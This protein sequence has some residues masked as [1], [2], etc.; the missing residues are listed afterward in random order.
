MWL[1]PVMHSACGL[2]LS[3]GGQAETWLGFP[4]PLG[5]PI[6]SLKIRVSVLIAF[7]K[8]A[9]CLF[10]GILS[11]GGV[12]A[13][14]VT[15]LAAVIKHLLRFMG[16]VHDGKSVVFTGTQGDGSHRFWAD[17]FPFP[18]VQDPR[19]PFSPQNGVGHTAWVFPPLLTWSR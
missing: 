8:E 1:G 6:L 19:R 18:S 14:L 12:A 10:L 17:A 15:C 3:T 4:F 7:G 5:L 2:I 13:V 11:A 9:T 16:T